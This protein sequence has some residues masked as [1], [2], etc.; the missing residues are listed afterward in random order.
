MQNLKL[1]KQE[2]LCSRTAIDAL[3]GAGHGVIAYPLRAVF[4][5]SEA[6]PGGCLPRFM[7]TIPKKKIRHAVGRV[8][9]R[10]RVRE[11]YRLHRHQLLDGALAGSGRRV[12]V[13]FV[14]LSKRTASYQVI[15]AKMQEILTAI[16]SKIQEQS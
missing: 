16:A 5:V 4:M 15:E 1:H 8:L 9:L 11:A 10:R 7:V 13:A 6:E 12:D 3:F 2:R 14:W